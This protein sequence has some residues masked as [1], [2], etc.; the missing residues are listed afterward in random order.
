MSGICR[1][2][3]I[4]PCAEGDRRSSEGRV[5]LGSMI[6]KMTI[7]KVPKETIGRVRAVLI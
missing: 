6:K 4:V 7:K 2:Q 3:S 5:D 1:T